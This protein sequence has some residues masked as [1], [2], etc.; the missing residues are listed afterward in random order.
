MYG[1]IATVLTS[2]GKSARMN[3]KVFLKLCF[4]KTYMMALTT[5]I[6]N[7]VMSMN[8]LNKCANILGKEFALFTLKITIN[9]MF[10]CEMLCQAQQS[11]YTLIVTNVAFY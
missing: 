5:F 10:G 6:M 2:K 8:V 1:T 11:I 7:F 4:G 3:M 9:T